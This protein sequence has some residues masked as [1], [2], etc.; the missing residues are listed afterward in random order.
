MNEVILYGFPVSPYVRS[1]RIASIEKGVNYRF[2][3]IELEVVNTDDYA[4]LNPF[5]KMPVLEQGNF[6][7][8]ETP[9]ILGYLDEGF[10]GS[11]LQ[12]SDPRSRAQMRKWMGIAANY[13]YPV[14]VSQLFLQRIVLPIMGA[15]TD[16]AI[17]ESAARSIAPYLDAIERELSGEFLVGNALSLADIMVGA[18]VD[19]IDMTKEGRMLINTRPK[20]SKWI[21]SLRDRESFKTTLADLLVGKVDR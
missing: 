18:M 7:L 19:Y 10:N 6:V 1:V 4:K 11:A 20:T 14:G 17:V 3:E 13:L 9:A 5:R 12:P 8:Y 15:E 21:A 2:K 16:E